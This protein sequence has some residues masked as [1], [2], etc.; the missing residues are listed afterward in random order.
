MAD[1][2]NS[3]VIQPMT[4]EHLAGADELRRLAGWNQTM[5]DWRWLLSLE[6]KGCFVAV[7]DGRV[8]G[9]VTTTGYEKA[10]GWIGMMLVHTDYQRRGVATQLMQRAVDSLR[11]RGIARIKLDATPAGRPVYE[12]LG[13]TVECTLTRYKGPRGNGEIIDARDLVESDWAEIDRIDAE[14]FGVSR[15]RLLRSV[16]QR[17]RAALVYPQEGAIRAWG[18]FRAGA[19]VDYLGPVVGRENGSSLVAALLQRARSEEVIWDVP[20]TNTAAKAIA[21]ELGFVPL[22]SLARMR[23]GG[24]TIAGNLQHQFAIA[25]PAVG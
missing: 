24:N 17:A 13:F 19:S 14:A 9:T 7:Q 23:L 12:R 15:L 25:D 22:R 11:N 10:L 5:E 8:I 21:D 16:A 3:A 20:D 18:V 1:E 2:R 4:P 6:P